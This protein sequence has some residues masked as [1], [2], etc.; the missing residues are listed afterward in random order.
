[1][2]S[3]AS[4]HPVGEQS[5][6]LEEQRHVHVLPKPILLNTAGGW[7]YAKSKGIDSERF[8]LCFI[9]GTLCGEDGL[10]F[11]F[12]LGPT[13][14]LQNQQGRS[15]MFEPLQNMPYIMPAEGDEEEVQEQLQEPQKKENIGGDPVKKQIERQRKKKLGAIPVKHPRPKRRNKSHTKRSP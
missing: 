13:P 1:M 4:L 10:S 6:T 3:G 14:H 7:V 9:I 12:H 8:A 2:D 15:I 11:T 5:L